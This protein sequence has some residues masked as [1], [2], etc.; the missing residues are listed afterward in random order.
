M[1]SKL[2][3]TAAGDQDPGRMRQHMHSR[4]SRATMIWAA[5]AGPRA[6]MAVAD[7]SWNRSAYDTPSYLSAISFSRSSA[8]VR[9]ARRR[10]PS[11]ARTASGLKRP[12]W[13]ATHE[14]RAPRNASHA[15]SLHTQHV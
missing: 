2:T 11:N 10:P 1:D 8:T 5:A 14:R 7:A 4:A 12:V 15:A 3:G 13:T 6:S 9:P